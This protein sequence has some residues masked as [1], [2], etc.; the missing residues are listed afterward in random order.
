L[1]NKTI[2]TSS[3]QSLIRVIDLEKTFVTARGI[4]P[5]LRLFSKNRGSVRAV[6]GISFNIER[7]EVFGLIGESGC[8]KTTTAKLLLRLEEPTKGEIYFDGNELTAM[9]PKELRKMRRRMQMIF[10]DPYESLNPGKRIFDIIA[11]PLVVHKMTNNKE[12]EER[13]KEIME[14]MELRPVKDLLGRF[15]HELSGGQRQR[16]AIARA[17]ILNP[18]FIVAD[19]PTSMVDVS[20]RAGI[21]NLLLSLKDELGL[22]CLFITHDLA[23]AKYMCNRIAVLYNGK[24]VEMGKK[25]ELIDNPL[26]PYT[27]ALITVA[28]S[29]KTFLAKQT[30]II[31]DAD[32][33]WLSLSS[34]CCRFA[35]RC[36]CENEICGQQEPDLKEVASGHWVAC[37][38]A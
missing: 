23:I 9:K 4:L 35:H 17:L 14:A 28:T 12:R 27:Q 31:K 13:V 18:D 37:H 19:E 29:L 26:H 30:E 10:Q 1:K 3:R 22:T 16:V 15:P 6:D 5:R 24:I 32:T 38:M 11:E 8:G 33:D 21:L 25:D 20:V 7:E 2:M 36:P 34:C